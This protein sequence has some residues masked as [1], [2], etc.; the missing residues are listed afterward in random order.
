MMMF[1]HGMVVITPDQ[2]IGESRPT[3][4]NLIVDKVR[5][6]IQA[7]EDKKIFDILDQISSGN[8]SL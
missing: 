3:Y 4:I 5:Q 7:E 1:D 2:Q 6:Q 8:I